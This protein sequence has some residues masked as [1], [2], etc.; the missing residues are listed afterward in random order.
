MKCMVLFRARKNRRQIPKSGFASCCYQNNRGAEAPAAFQL[1]LQQPL[2]ILTAK[3][4][5]PDNQ[6]GYRSTY[7]QKIFR[8]DQDQGHPDAD[9]KENQSA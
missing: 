7:P 2:C 3:Q 8:K 5:V 6:Q 9:R 1:L 4:V